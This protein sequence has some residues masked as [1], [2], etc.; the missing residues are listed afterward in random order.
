MR[1]Q[2]EHKEFQENLKMLTE[3]KKKNCINKK[4]KKDCAKTIRANSR[5]LKIERMRNT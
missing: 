4:I 5:K 3:K 1:K 2:K